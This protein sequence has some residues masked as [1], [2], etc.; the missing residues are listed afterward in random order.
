MTARAV[1]T[2]AC[3]LGEGPLWHPERG[4][5]FWLDI[6]GRR[7][8]TIEGGAEREWRFE[9]QVS[10]AGWIDRDRLLLASE[11][12]LWDFDLTG[13]AAARLC[14][15]EAEDP[16]T[17]SNDGRADPWGGFWIG[18]MGKRAE[19][20]AGALYRFHGGELR[21]LAGG[22]T[23]P[24]AICF[25]PDGAC[26]F[27]AD[28]AEGRVL[29]Q[30]LDAAGWPEGAPEV[31]LDAAGAGWGPDGAVT[32]AEGCLWLAQW[33]AGRVARYAPDGAWLS[34]REVPTPQATCPAF[35]GPE[36]TTLFVTTAAEGGLPP[37]AGR[38]Y[39]IET[40][41]RGRPEPRVRL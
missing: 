32:D 18:T 24:N 30:P 6:L 26:A 7:L 4:Q 23:I 39:A 5:L 2:T 37:P 9:E 15:L 20:G 33:G 12:G 38:T 36:L 11:T 8:C 16:A 14:P 1:G 22:V 35:G 10:A 13:G 17:R 25:S 3:A 41:I 28:T 21:R 31:F 34:H 40:G 29:R 19:R 27:H